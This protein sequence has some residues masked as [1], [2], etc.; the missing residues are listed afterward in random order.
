MCPAPTQL[1]FVRLCLQ[2]V[3]IFKT[4]GVASITVQVQADGFISRGGPMADAVE[5]AYYEPAAIFDVKS[6]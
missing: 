5:S 6:L 1:R 3:S 2:V 4:V